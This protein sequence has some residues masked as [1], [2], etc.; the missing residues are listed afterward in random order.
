MSRHISYEKQTLE[1][2]NPIARY[3]HKKRYAYS[4][5]LVDK[6]LKSNGKLLDFGCGKGDFLNEFF[7]IRPDARL[8]GF[9]PESNHTPKDYAAVSSMDHID[10]RSVDVVVCFETLEHL[11]AD[12]L[13]EFIDQVKRVLVDGGR[14]IISVPI[15]GGPTLLLKESNRM[16]LFRKKSDYSFWEVLTVSF[17]GKPTPRPD[18]IRTTHKGFD[19][20]LIEK[21]LKSHFILISKNFSPFRTLPWYLNSQVFYLFKL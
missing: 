6:E 1:T 4:F 19:F 21:E 10:D 9:D 8:L 14:I 13:K 20:K 3:A 18:N 5:A 15:I 2:P 12:E 16:F 17:S 11:Y 7:R